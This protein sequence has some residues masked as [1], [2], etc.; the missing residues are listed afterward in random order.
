MGFIL[1]PLFYV[2]LQRDVLS[3][4]SIGGHGL[5]A[6]FGLLAMGVSTYFTIQ[7]ILGNNK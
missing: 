3:F 1:P 7:D 5:I 2:S 6:L 4:G